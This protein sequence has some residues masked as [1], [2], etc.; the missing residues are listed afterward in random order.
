[1]G[2]EVEVIKPGDGSS[3]PT[4]G[5]TVQVH[6][7]GTLTN[8]KEFD[9]SRSRGKPFEFTLGVGQ[10]IK[11]WDEGVAK[12]SLGERAKLICTPDYAYGAEGYPNVIPL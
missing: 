8:G 1:M 9:S 5:Q 2:V 10:G 6:Y 4:K 12:M 3:Y 11:A 7:V